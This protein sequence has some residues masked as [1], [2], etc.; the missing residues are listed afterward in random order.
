MLERRRLIGAGSFRQAKETS[1]LSNKSLNTPRQTSRTN[2]FSTLYISSDDSSDFSEDYNCCFFISPLDQIEI[3]IG[4]NIFL[5][6]RNRLLT[7]D[8]ARGIFYKLLKKG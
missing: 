2:S 6:Y 8:E 7:Y 5:V 3:G 4:D 1:S